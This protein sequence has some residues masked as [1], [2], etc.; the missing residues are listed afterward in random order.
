[1]IAI[2][3]SQFLPWVPYFYKML[4]ADIFVIL[5]DVQFQKN[6]VQNRNKIKTPKGAAWL[7]VP[8]S[9][10]FGSKIN[11][12]TI[13][14]IVEYE[15]V[16]DIL[17]TN[18]KRS[19]YFHKIY[20]MI[21]RIFDKKINNL[22]ELNI[23]LLD[24]VLEMLGKRPT[25]YYSSTLKISEKKDDLVIEIIKHF[26]DKEYLSGA[27]AFKYMDLNKFKK[28]GIKVYTYEFVY[29]EYRQLWNKR[30]GFLNDLSIID[31]MFNNLEDSLAY[32]QNNGSLKNVI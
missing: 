25:I 21:K 10:Q 6:G 26:K 20:T 28:A 2:H 5:D 13:S 22:N 17:I 11:E 4:K 29:N 7:T 16:S 3:Q 18:Y 23:S 9:L 15:R 19:I 30:V 32:I 8:V 24:Q 31:L 12:V 1:M 27:G 14:N